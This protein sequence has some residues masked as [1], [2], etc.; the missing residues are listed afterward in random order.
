M[1]K[2]VF[3]EGYWG[4]QLDLATG[5]LLHIERRR[6]DFIENLHDGSILDHLFATD[7]EWMKLIYTTIMGSGILLFSVTGIWLYLGPRRMRRR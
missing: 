3:I 6:S 2:F 1:V 5:D 7:G 4:I